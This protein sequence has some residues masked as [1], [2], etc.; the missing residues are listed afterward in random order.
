MLRVS[1]KYECGHAFAVLAIVTSS[2]WLIYSRAR[3]PSGTLLTVQH[4]P[5]LNAIFPWVW[6]E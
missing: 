2:A 3:R 4:V 6:P 1:G 5:R